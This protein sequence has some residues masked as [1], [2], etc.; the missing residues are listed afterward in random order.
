M[1]VRR[2]RV[3]SPDSEYINKIVGRLALRIRR[4]IQLD[5]VTNPE[6]F[7][8]IHETPQMVDYEFID[9]QFLGIKVA[10]HGSENVF[11]ISE[12]ANTGDKINK[13]EGSGAILRVLGDEVLKNV[14]E[15]R[16]CQII[17]VVSP[18]GGSGKTT[19]ALCV[20]MRLS[21]MKRKVLYIDAENAQNY[22]EKLSNDDFRKDYADKE[23]AGAIINLTSNSYEYV[24][25]HIIH[26]VFDYLPEFDKY[27]F[28]YHIDA[29][30]L[31]KLAQSI[32][33]KGIYDYIIVEQESSIN[34]QILPYAMGGNELLITI[35][36]VGDD[37]RLKRFIDL[38][39]GYTG[40]VLIVQNVVSGEKT[41]IYGKPVAEQ[42]NLDFNETLNGLM[43]KGLYRKAAEAV[44]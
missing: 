3:S 15:K 6:H 29:E 43:E 26:G 27:L 42:V 14:G 36:H 21:Q 8:K 5:F 24:K 38:F 30:A 35:D 9:E 17:N 19:T 10:N 40:N 12:N 11:I 33:A 44:L 37:V 16:S 4:D 25:K 13:L 34:A 32:S 7:A 18:Y 39:D 23:L 1:N 31:N 2:I 20:A 22:Y 28:S 41:E